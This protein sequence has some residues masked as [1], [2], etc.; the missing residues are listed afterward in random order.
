MPRIIKIAAAQLGPVPKS[1]SRTTTLKRLIELL[2]EAKSKQ[3]DL[4]VFPEAALTPFFPHWYMENTAEIDEYFEKEMPNENVQALF[5]EAKKLE[6]GFSL[7]YAELSF[8][9][10][11]KHYYNSSIL[12]DKNGEIIGKYRKI[13]L[14]GFKEYQ[15]GQPFQNLE[16]MYFEVGNLGFPTWNAFG[17]IFGMCICNDRRWPET[18]RLLGLGGAEVI[19]LGYNTPVNNPALPE[20]DHLTSFHNL[21]SMQAGAYQNG[22]WVVGVAKAGLEEGVMQVGQTSIIAPSGEIVA[23]ASTLEDEL[24]TYD[25]NIDLAQRYKKHLLN[26]SENRKIQHYTKI[27][28]QTDAISP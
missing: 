2:K 13:H 17:G 23:M 18:Y 9:N 28:Q 25:C 20:S 5:S 26:F 10:Q 7:G 21:L 12:V 16:K 11:E 19:L 8:E 27:S 15:D 1:H 4:V 14:P 24:I 3:C 6:I 22:T